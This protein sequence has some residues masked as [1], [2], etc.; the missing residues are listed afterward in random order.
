MRYNTYNPIY[1]TVAKFATPLKKLKKSGCDM[2]APAGVA[3]LKMF[4][5]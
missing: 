3:K 1:C 2:N 5:D 4:Q